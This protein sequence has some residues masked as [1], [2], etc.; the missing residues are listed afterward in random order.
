[1]TMLK[2]D[3]ESAVNQTTMFKLD[4]K[5]PINVTTI[6]EFGLYLDHLIKVSRLNRLTV[7][8][9]INNKDSPGLS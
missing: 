9:K 1:M 5:S 6:S 4:F 7:I 8:N 3:F 2:S